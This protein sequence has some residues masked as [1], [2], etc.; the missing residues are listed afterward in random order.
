M[1]RRHVLSL[2]SVFSMRHAYKPSSC[3]LTLGNDRSSVTLGPCRP[4]IVALGWV[5]GAR[6]RLAQGTVV[7][8]SAGLDTFSTRYQLRLEYSIRSTTQRSNTSSSSMG[9]L[10]GN[11]LRLRKPGEE[12]T[13][14]VNVWHMIKFT[15]KSSFKCLTFIKK[16]YKIVIILYTV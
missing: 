1:C 14:C 12:N 11:T 16:Y 15:N 5:R 9:V 6:V 7:G 4:A 8:S 13:D 10:E 3:W 2:L